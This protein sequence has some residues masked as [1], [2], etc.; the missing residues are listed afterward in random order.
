MIGCHSLGATVS[1]AI[2]PSRMAT[3]RRSSLAMPGRTSGA[4]VERAH[5]A[6]SRLQQVAFHARFHANRFRHQGQQSVIYRGNYGISQNK[7]LLQ[8]L[9]TEGAMSG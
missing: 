2:S 3:W 6:N 8:S 1:L 7:R 5:I 9:S 4:S